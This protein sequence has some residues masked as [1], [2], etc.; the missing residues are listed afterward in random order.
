MMTKAKTWTCKCGETFQQASHLSNHK[1]MKHVPKV[2]IDMP[3]LSKTNEFTFTRHIDGNFHC[4]VC[5]SIQPSASEFKKHLLSQC[6]A[7]KEKHQCSHC[8][9]CFETHIKLKLHLTKEHGFDTMVIEGQIGIKENIMLAKKSN[10]KYECPFCPNEYDTLPSLTQHVQHRCDVLKES[11]DKSTF[12]CEKCGEIFNSRKRLTTH[13]YNKHSE[14]VNVNTGHGMVQI[15]R[16]PNGRVTCPI[17]K[18]FSTPTMQTLVLHIQQKCTT[19]KS[20][21]YRCEDCN[22]RYKLKKSLFKH[23]YCVHSP[24]I[25][26]KYQSSVSGQWKNVTKDRTPKNEL[27]CPSCKIGYIDV[28]HL[29]DHISNKCSTIRDSDNDIYKFVSSSIITEKT[30]D[31]DVEKENHIMID[32]D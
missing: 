9:S 19:P 10:D 3:G 14:T 23:K 1:D 21:E 8:N 7:E 4:T 15:Q 32:D 31:L 26:L 27:N 11:N 30:I 16:E 6:L 24:S 5:Q 12:H 28:N 17:C 20:D 2:I 25:V 18:V 13:N 22:S 29:I